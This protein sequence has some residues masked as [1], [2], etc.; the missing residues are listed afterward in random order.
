MPKQLQNNDKYPGAE[1]EHERKRYPDRRP[2]TR[3]K[4]ML[5]HP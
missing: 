4:R 5:E 1:Q 2:L 3:M